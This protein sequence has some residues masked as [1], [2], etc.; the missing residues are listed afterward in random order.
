[1]TK[2]YYYRKRLMGK[3]PTHC[4]MS[5]PQHLLQTEGAG[6]FFRGLAPTL[7]RE[8][9]GC[10]L[11]FL[12]NE[13]AKEAIC[14]GHRVRTGQELRF[15]TTALP[16]FQARLRCDQGH[17]NLCIMTSPSRKSELGLTS[18]TI[19]GGVA[20]VSFWLAIFPVDEFMPNTTIL[21]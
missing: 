8:V 18:R 12:G 20:G 9:P 14:R 11:F 16:K 19:C 15:T 13:A 7:G 5:P 21:L 3:I 1:M 2:V 4:F 10:C 17:H 6:S